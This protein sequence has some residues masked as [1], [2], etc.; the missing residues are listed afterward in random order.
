MYKDNIMRKAELRPVNTIEHI[1]TT[2]E[3][4]PWFIPKQQIIDDLIKGHKVA[5]HLKWTA[6]TLE[7]EVLNLIQ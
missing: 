6:N 5:I 7:I 2:I 1:R 4:L 3:Y